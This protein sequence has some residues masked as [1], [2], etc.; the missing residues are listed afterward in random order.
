MT[1]DNEKRENINLS[2]EGTMQ[3]EAPAIEVVEIVCQN[4]PDWTHGSGC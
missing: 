1:T 4:T 2:I 3:Y